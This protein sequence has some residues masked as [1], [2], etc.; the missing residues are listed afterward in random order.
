M[1]SSNGHAAKPGTPYRLLTGRR[2]PLER[3]CNILRN[4]TSQAVFLMAGPG[5]GKSTLTEAITERL[6]QEMIIVQIHGSSS[7]SGVPFGV[8]APYTAELTAEDSVSPVAVLR[9]VWRYFEKLKAGKDTP[10]LL[11]MDDAHH[12]DEATASIVAD[13]ISAGWATV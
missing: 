13:L 12:L 5:I 10:L 6:A 7:L 2:E 1:D 4:R 3:I 9:S 8:L 11:M